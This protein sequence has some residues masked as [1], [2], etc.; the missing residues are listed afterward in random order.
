MEMIMRILLITLL[1]LAVFFLIRAAFGLLFKSSDQPDKMVR[2]LT[3]RIGISI[4]CLMVILGSYAMGW[5]SP[6]A[7]LKYLFQPVN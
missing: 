5:L 3:W 2:D 7:S 6:S 4:V 1:I